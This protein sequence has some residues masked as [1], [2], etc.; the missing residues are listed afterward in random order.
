MLSYSK[1]NQQLYFLNLLS[2]KLLPLLHSFKWD[3][4]GRDQPVYQH[5][6]I[7]SVPSLFTYAVSPYMAHLD[8]GSCMSA[9]VLLILLNEL[10]KRDKMRG[11]PS[12]LSFSQRV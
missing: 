3:N 7:R 8:R 2:L 6:E 1:G 9:H 4:K 12:I 10:R 11:L 5:S